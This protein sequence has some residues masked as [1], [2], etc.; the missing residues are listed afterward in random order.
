M[1]LM[2]AGIVVLLIVL[3]PF[4]FDLLI[5]KC[6]HER[7]VEVCP[8]GLVDLKTSKPKGHDPAS[9]PKKKEKEKKKSG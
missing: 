5:S 2:L 8:L 1:E 9:P 7:L 4:F 3:D 6:Q